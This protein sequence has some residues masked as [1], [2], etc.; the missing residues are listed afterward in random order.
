MSRVYIVNAKRSP[1]GKFLGSLSNIS[2]GDLAAEVIKNIIEETNLDKY[3]IDEVI[4]GNVLSAGQS[5]GVA[6]QA[7]IYAGIPK[8]VPA[9][10]LNM[11][12]GSGMKSVMNAYAQIKSGM[13]N[14]IIAGGVEVM[15]QAPFISD[16]TIR[17]GNKMGNIKLNDSLILDGLTDSFNNYHMGVTAENIVE[18]YNIS[19]EDQ[20]LFAINSQKKAIK[21]I[22]EGKF[23]DEIVPIH[24]SDKNDTIVFDCDEYPNRTTNY[25]KISKLKP[26]FK[27]NGTITAGNSSGIND[28]AAALILVSEQAVN[29]YNL[30]PMAEIIS[31]GQGGLDPSIMGM[32]P[33][34]AI[35]DALSKVDVSFKDIDLIELNE[36][37]AA[38]S[39]GVL[40]E[41]K[42]IYNIDEYWIKERVNVNGG[43]ISLGHP[44]GAS[45]SR[46]VTTLVHEMNRRE[47]LYGLA[48]LC[49]GGGMGT[50]ILLKRV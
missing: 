17:K 20:D 13:A 34:V 10:T 26:A 47:S 19:R 7:S 39:I 35:K 30:K 41:L 25:E 32:G 24:I 31:I 29:K 50:A 28:G 16:T 42:T 14:I 49:I 2:A 22:D 18:M 45:G 6:R 37:F 1:I 27:T 33:V 38:Q 9:Y 46:I 3:K 15:S 40:E 48:S 11:V 36:A 43:A 21:S 8:E 5:Q 23:I 12:C 4:L 44:L